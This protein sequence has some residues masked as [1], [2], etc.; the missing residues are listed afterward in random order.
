MAW[1]LAGFVLMALA[2]PARAQSAVDGDTIKVGGTT[3]RLWGI[4]SPETRQQC[5]D[6]WPAGIEATRAIS[7]LMQGKA[8]D[9]QTRGHDRYGRTIGLCRADGR[10]LGQ[11]MVRAGMALAFTRYSVDYVA[12]EAAAKAALLGVHAHDCIP[13]W[14]WRARQRAN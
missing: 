5:A 2:V 13:A 8:I 6:G 7:G 12:D 1:A 9:C 4:D 3:Y 14:E 10:D 11:S